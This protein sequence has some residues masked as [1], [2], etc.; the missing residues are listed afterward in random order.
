LNK[1]LNRWD[2]GYYGNKYNIAC[3]SQHMTQ[4]NY[5][6]RRYIVQIARFDPAKG[7]PTVIDAYAEFR[8]LA[9]QADI[10]DIPQLVV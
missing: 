9:D 2:S 1:P 6:A 7:I 10:T 3:A 4:L 8:R 5:P